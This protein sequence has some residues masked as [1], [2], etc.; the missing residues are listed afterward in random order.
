MEE[1][2]MENKNRLC[3]CPN[4]EIKFFDEITESDKPAYKEYD[5]DVILEMFKHLIPE[6]KKEHDELEPEPYEIT[7]SR[8]DY[9]IYDE[10]WYRLK[11]QGLPDEYYPILVEADKNRVEENK[12]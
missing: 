5:V 1:K 11:F 3:W 12:E 7:D 8:L 4:D 2:D 6:D 10:D 9:S